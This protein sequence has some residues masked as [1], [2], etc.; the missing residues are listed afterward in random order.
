VGLR[1]AKAGDEL[2]IPKGIRHSVHNTH[3]GTTRRLFGYG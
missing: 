1:H 2:F 3:R